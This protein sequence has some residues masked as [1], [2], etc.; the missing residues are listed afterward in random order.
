MNAS[1][2][3]SSEGGLAAA[4]TEVTGQITLSRPLDDVIPGALPELFVLLIQTETSAYKYELC[5]HAK[6]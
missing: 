5:I 2:Y 6:V 1:P 3:T 4:V